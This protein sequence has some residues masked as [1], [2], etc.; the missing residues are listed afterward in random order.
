MTRS[1]VNSFPPHAIAK[2]APAT[3]SQA[4]RCRRTTVVAG[5]EA[6]DVSGLGPSRVDEGVKGCGAAIVM[7]PGSLILFVAAD[8]TLRAGHGRWSSSTHVADGNQPVEEFYELVKTTITRSDEI[9][10]RS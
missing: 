7:V 8:G 2:A 10:C 6:P 4:K 5:L 1:G 9:T 3:Q